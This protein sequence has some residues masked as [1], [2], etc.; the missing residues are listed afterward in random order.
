MEIAEMRELLGEEDWVGLWER[1]SDVDWEYVCEHIP[2]NVQWRMVVASVIVERDPWDEELCENLWGDDLWKDMPD[3]LLHTFSCDCLERFL[4]SEESE[5][6]ILDGNSWDAIKVRR[7]WLKGEA[8]EEDLESVRGRL[9][10][11]LEEWYG[12]QLRNNSDTWPGYWILSSTSASVSAS[13]VTSYTA[14]PALGTR[15][16]EWQLNHF[17]KLLIEIG[18]RELDVL[19]EDGFDEHESHLEG[20]GR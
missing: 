1:R 10:V 18:D 16:V 13:W 11:P 3:F 7:K 4:R 12:D 2:W 15:E 8:T 6:I 9:N 5:N 17:A 14:R 20:G 19:E